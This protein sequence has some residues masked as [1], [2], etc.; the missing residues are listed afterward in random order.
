MNPTWAIHQGDVIRG[1]IWGKE[2]C[3]VGD[4]GIQL[5]LAA[6][7]FQLLRI[8]HALLEILERLPKREEDR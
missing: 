5:F 2:V 1:N 3:S 8:H 4:I 7:F 6:L